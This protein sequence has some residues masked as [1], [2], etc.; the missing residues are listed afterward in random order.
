MHEERRDRT[1]QAHLESCPACRAEEELDRRLA[2]AI[3][4]MPR[5]PAPR[6]LVGAVMAELRPSA[7]VHRPRSPRPSWTLRPWEITW[8][9]AS[10]L[11]LI[12]LVPSLFGG[13]IRP[14]VA[15]LSSWFSGW[16]AP[17]TTASAD[18]SAFRIGALN[19]SALLE[20]AGNLPTPGSSMPWISGAAAFALGFFL[21]LSWHGSTPRTEEWEN[22]HA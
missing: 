9:S 1:V 16:T 2:E 10:C 3:A 4:S 7:R 19:V 13:S 22:T 8:L 17:L 15:P 14:V 12:A 20:T 6:G 5:I 11:L 18:L 21:L